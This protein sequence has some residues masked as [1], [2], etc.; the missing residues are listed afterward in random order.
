MTDEAPRTPD[1][2]AP[3]HRFGAPR[4]ASVPR[5]EHVRIT[6]PDLARRAMLEKT[7][8]RLVLAAAGFAVLFAAVGL[9]LADATIIQPVLPRQVAARRVEPPTAPVVTADDQTAEQ[10]TTPDVVEPHVRAMITDRNGQILAVSLPTASV[11]ANPRELTDAADTAHKLVS[12]LP[13]LD[14][15]DLRT[16]LADTTKQFVYIAR[17]IT[18]RDELRINGLGIPGVYFQPTERRRYPMGRVAAQVLGGVDVDGHGVAGAEK[19]FEQ[20]LR[21]EPQPLRL[22][23]DVRVQAL[24]RD[25]LSGAM[26][27]FEAIGGAG[28][29]MD[30]H[31]GEIIAMVSLPDYD[32]NDFGRADPNARR[33][34]AINSVFEPGS[35]FKLQNVSAALDDGVVNVWNGFDATAPIHAGRYTIN[36]FQGKHRFLYVPEI[37]AYSSNIG[38]AHMAAAVGAERQRAWMEKAGMMARVPFELP[39][40]AAPL[41]PPVRAWKELTTMTIGFGQGIAVTPLHVV[42]GT[43]TVANGGIKLQPTILALGPDEAPPQGTR[44]MQQSTSDTVRRLMRLVVTEGVGKSAEVPGYFVGGKTGT[45]Q[46]TAGGRGY[47]QNAR[48]AAF[49]GAFPMNAPRYLIYMMLDEPKPNAS[50]HGYATAGWVVAPA[51]AKVIAQAA[52]ML[53]LLPDTDHAAEIDAALAIPLQPGKPAGVAK[54]AV[55]VAR[56]NPPAAAAPALSVPTVPPMRDLRH[57]A[58]YLKPSDAVR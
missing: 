4:E 29:V 8:G 9:K 21:D 41:V 14:E 43:A 50:T 16:R 49:A 55:P 36:D 15:V 6:A 47:V 19:A 20:R 30:V 38:A 7:R 18:P 27:D 13:K 53:G 35:T 11:Y 34:R 1:P 52:P 58:T 22:S 23:I 37:I 54:P 3:A 17:Q 25:E 44:I 51:A 5:M 46:K 26:A 45:A 33:N 40:T 24:V 32:A 57:E 42:V 39:E 28:I 31:T 56:A 48:V 10:D 2:T 12:V